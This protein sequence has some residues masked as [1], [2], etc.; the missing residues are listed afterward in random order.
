[1]FVVKIS[2]CSQALSFYCISPVGQLVLG[3]VGKKSTCHSSE[4]VQWLKF[5]TSFPQLIMQDLNTLQCNVCMY[6]NFMYVN[7]CMN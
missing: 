6:V 2:Y 7:V 4:F 5:M 3:L 1:M